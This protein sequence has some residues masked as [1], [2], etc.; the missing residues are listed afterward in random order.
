MRKYFGLLA[1]FLLVISFQN[2]AQVHNNPEQASSLGAGVIQV[3]TKAITQLVLWNPNQDQYLD[4][5]LN[6]GKM[7]AYE[8]FGEIRGASYCLSTEELFQLKSILTTSDICEPKVD[9]SVAKD[10]V[11]TMLYKY[12]YV[13]IVQDSVEYRLGEMNTG[14]DIPTDL[15]GE[16]G[17]RLR[18][19]AAAVVGNLEARACK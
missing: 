18:A 4:V 9:Y 10:R 1:V 8:N 2:C 14:C 17:S 6:D 12:P 13:S 11:C 19:F 3:S 7:I 16:Q 5:N 15:C